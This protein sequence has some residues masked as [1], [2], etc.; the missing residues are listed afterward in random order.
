MVRSN[1]TQQFSCKVVTKNIFFLNLIDFV[2]FSWVTYENNYLIL[3][4]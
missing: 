3:F 1:L 4:L 2:D